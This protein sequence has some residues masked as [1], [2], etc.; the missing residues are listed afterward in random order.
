[1]EIVGKTYGRVSRRDFPIGRSLHGFIGIQQ[2]VNIA[3][4]DDNNLSLRFWERLG[5]N[6]LSRVLLG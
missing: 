4:N 3:N 1:M 2:T 6:I 5:V